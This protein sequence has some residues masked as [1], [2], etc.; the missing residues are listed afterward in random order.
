MFNAG[1]LTRSQLQAALHSLGLLANRPPTFSSSM[2]R[3][4]AVHPSTPSAQHSRQAGSIVDG[5]WH[6][7]T[8]TQSKC[9][10]ASHR[11]KALPLR[12][13]RVSS[14]SQH[15]QPEQ[16][17]A[18]EAESCDVLLS[19]GINL[20]Q[21]LIGEA[22]FSHE[23]AHAAQTHAPTTPVP[24][25]AAKPAPDVTLSF[26]P[27]ESMCSTTNRPLQHTLQVK[28]GAKAHMHGVSL[29]QLLAFVQ[30]VQQQ[31]SGI[32]AAN[33]AA[34]LQVA[35]TD[36]QNAVLDKIAQ[37]CSQNKQANMAYVGIGKSRVQQQ[38]LQQPRAV[39]DRASASLAHHGQKQQEQQ[40]A[41]THKWQPG[42]A[43]FHF[44][45]VIQ[46]S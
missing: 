42:G 46:A 31:N 40:P 22:S 25:N 1:L 7:L 30:L 4:A 37:T 43:L 41:L 26:S 44:H 16:A 33:A 32:P 14:S 38:S 6:L 39:H 12:S 29:Q 19:Q 5:L 15:L 36:R 18:D 8:G 23:P 11:T 10:S 2:R 27:A 20:W 35:L 17:A 13:G 21:Q 9:M 45:S 34:D 3:A 24:V 28:A